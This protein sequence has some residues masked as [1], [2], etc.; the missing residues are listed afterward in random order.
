MQDDTHIGIG[1]V[2]AG[3]A[4]A[5]LHAALRAAVNRFPDELAAAEIP[6]DPA[7]FRTSYP[8]ALPRFEAARAG[9]SRRAEIARAVVAAADERLVMQP[10]ST[11][12]HEAVAREAEPHGTNT[13]R[14]DGK[15]RLH[16]QVPLDGTARKGDELV[17]TVSSMVARGSASSSVADA[18]SWLV[19][20]AGS[21]GIDLS[22][23]RI[24]ML[25]AGAELAPT[26]LWLEG[27][28]DVLWV[29]VADPPADLLERDDLA[30][31]LRWIPGGTDLLTDP[32]RVRATIE[33]FADGERIDLGLYA[34]AGGHAREWR[35]TAAMN[36]IVDALPAGLVQGVAMLLSPTTCGVLTDA[37]LAGE[38]TRRAGA[39]RWLRT[40]DRTHAL[41]KG[42]GHTVIGTTAANRGIVSI[43]GGSY[44][45]AQY[46]GKMLAAEVWA[47]GDPAINVSANTAGVS[48]TES[49]HHPVFET[50][51][52]GAHALGIETFPPA[53]TAALNGLLTLHDRLDPAAAERPLDE[54]FATRVHGGIYVAPYPIDPA[55]R[56]ATAIGLLKDPRRIA[57]LIRR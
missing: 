30:G 46:V 41:G 21:D 38:A 25:G 18:I 39:T 20:A 36:A 2:D 6:E 24:A 48:L 33:E 5:H 16:P 56:V 51:F 37:E 42:D 1:F 47:S 11:P 31:T 40:L 27:G 50:A 28:A 49:L 8:E 43:Q 52:A 53:T 44:Q 14:F 26:R 45:G 17:E 34:Y 29:D 23:R 54:L 7:A 13:H 19:D 15:S 3:S 55:L 32:H 9:S 35:L 57:T 10:D 22:R 4:T 12:I